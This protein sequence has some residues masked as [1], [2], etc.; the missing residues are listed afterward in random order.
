MKLS[1]K[2]LDLAKVTPIDEIQEK[3]VNPD[4]N[5][6]LQFG[7]EY[8]DS[9]A[10]GIMHHIESLLAERLNCERDDDGA[11]YGVFS[12]ISVLRGLLNVY[13]EQTS[14]HPEI[15]VLQTDFSSS[16]IDTTITVPFNS[17]SPRA[18][19]AV[20]TKARY[21]PKLRKATKNIQSRTELGRH[22]LGRVTIIDNEFYVKP[23]LIENTK[24]P[25]DI[26]W[27]AIKSGRV[28]T[29]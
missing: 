5:D 11:Y 4:F 29:S 6:S 26:T 2:N 12:R 28:G 8:K 13:D 14:I 25:G 1:I 18:N 16:K 27:R 20:S 23:P 19:K 22:L 24:F 3:L 15:V 9:T 17:S 10:S 7:F 21:S